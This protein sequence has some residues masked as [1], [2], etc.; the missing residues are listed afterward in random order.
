MPIYLGVKTDRRGAQVAFEVIARSFK[1]AD[2]LAEAHG[3]DALI[4]G[5]LSC[6]LADLPRAT[7]V[8]ATT[9]RTPS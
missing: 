8:E 2:K 6:R 7:R 4:C 5:T 9:K 1:E 3:K